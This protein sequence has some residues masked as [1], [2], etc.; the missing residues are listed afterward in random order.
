[1]QEG[2]YFHFLSDKSSSIYFQQVSFRIKGTLQLDLFK[3]SME[4]LFKRYDILRTIFTHEK[5]DLPL[6]VVLK[7]QPIDFYFE[8]ISE[9]PT[10]EQ[11]EEFIRKHKETEKE[12]PFDLTRDILMRT[13]LIQINESQYE[14]TWSFPHILMDGWCAHLLLSEL[15]EIYRAYVEDREFHLPPFRQYGE[16][17]KWLKTKSINKTKIYWEKYLSGYSG[18]IHIP[19]RKEYDGEMDDTRIDRVELELDTEKNAALNEIAGKNQVTLNSLIQAVWGILLSKFNNTQDMVFGTVVYG[20]PSEIK[21]VET[22]VGLFINTIPLRVKY[23]DDTPF[24][25]LIKTVQDDVV[26]SETHHYYSLAEIQANSSLKQ[27][28]LDHL[29]VSEDN[30]MTEDH[31]M[32]IKIGSNEESIQLSHFTVFNRGNYPINIIVVPR[33]QASGLKIIWEFNWDFYDKQEIQRVAA[34]FEL[35]LKQIILNPRIEISNIGIISDPEKNQLLY[36]FNDTREEGV[37]HKNETIHHLFEKQVEKTPDYIIIDYPLNTCDSAERCI[38]GRGI[39]TY[40]DLNEKSNQLARTLKGKG[41]KPGDIMGIMIPSS[42][43]MALGLLGI[44]K[45]GGAYL[46]I[47]PNYPA[48]RVN[49]ILKDSDIG[50]VLASGGEDEIQKKI[51]NAG[52]V[53]VLD[54]RNHE[55]VSYPGDGLNLQEGNRSSSL[56]YV[57]Y[58]SGT[59]GW[60]KGVPIDHKNVTNVL[61]HRKQ[62]FNLN[63][64]VTML[65]LLSYSFDGF[66]LS[67]FAPVVSGAQVILLTEEDRKDIARIKEAIVKHRITHFMAV[68]L[69]YQAIIEGFTPRE[70][71]SLEVVHIGADK[72]IPDILNITREN[73][74]HIEIS[75]EYGVTETTIIST[76]HRHQQKDKQ[77]HIG[78]P[79]WNTKIYIQDKRQRL[80]PLGVPGEICIGGAGIARGYLNNPELSKEKFIENPYIPGEKIYKSGDLGKHQPGGKIEFLGRIDNQVKI[81]GLRIEL[82]EIETQLLK[83]KEIKEAV[84]VDRKD[85]QGNIFLCAYVVLNGNIS[86]EIS[87]LRSLL[88]GKLPDYM[89]PAYFVQLDKIPLTDNNKVDRKALPDPGIKTVD[90]YIAPRNEIEEKLVEIWSDVLQIEK[91]A[92]GIDSNFFE[93]GGH[94]LKATILAGKIHKE[95]QVNIEIKNL[96]KLTSIRE[97]SGFI[98]ESKKVEYTSIEPVEKREYYGVSPAQKRLYLAQQTT[99]HAIGY[100]ITGFFKIHGQPDKD[101]LEY[102]FKQLE[103]RH[104]SLRTSFHLIEGMIIQKIHEENE[105]DFHIQYQESI[106][107]HKEEKPGPDLPQMIKNF[108]RPFDLS[109]LPLWRV[110]LIKCAE[111]EYIFMVDMH[112]IISDGWSIS[113]LIKEIMVSYDGKECQLAPLYI[114]YKEFSHWQ[115]HRL[116]CQDIKPQEEFWL[117]QFKGEEPILNLPTDYS[118][119]LQRSFEGKSLHFAIDKEKTRQLRQ[120]V[121]RTN[122]RLYMMLLAMFNIF[123]AKICSQEDVVLGIAVSGRNHVDLENTFG[124]FVNILPFRTEPAGEKSFTRYLEEV[125]E[126]TLKVYENQDY[127]YEDLVEK[128]VKTRDTSRNPLFDVMFELQD[129]HLQKFELTGLNLVPHEYEEEVSQ[130]DMFLLGEESEDNLFFNLTFSPVLFKKSTAERLANYF[131]KILS[132]ILA[133]PGKR[134]ADIDIITDE[135]KQ[136][137]LRE[138]NDTAAAYPHEKTFNQL[139]EE[140]VRCTPGHIALVHNETRITYN[141]LNIKANQLARVLRTKGVT[142]DTTV[143][144]M[145]DHSMEMI[146]GLIGILKA[147]ASFVPIDPAYP[148]ERVKV[149]L[150]DC[151][152]KILL[153][154]TNIFKHFSFTHLQSY[155]LTRGEF[156]ITEPRPPIKDLDSIQ[157]PDRSMVDYEKYARSI[158]EAMVKHSISLQA[159]RGC[160]YNCAYCC[161][162][163]PRTFVTRSA[164][165]IFKEV[166][167]YYDMGFRRFAFYDDIFNLDVENSRRFFRMISQNKMNVHLFFPTGFR[168]DILTKE[169]ID[170]VVEAGAVNIALSLETASP[171]MQKLIRKNLQIERFRENV[172]YLC[173]K[174]P[175]VILELQLM[176]GFPTETEE[177]AMMNL[178]FIKS[179]KWIHFPYLHILKIH[180][181]TDMEKIALE[182]GITRKAIERS[183]TLAYH[184]LPE[185]LPFDKNF[186]LEVQTEFLN[187]YFLR[188]ERLLHVLPYQ[189]KVLTKDEILQKY[190]SYLPVKINSIEALLQFVDITEQE[191]KVKD[192]LDEDFMSVPHLNEK[193][194]AYFHSPH[195]ETTRDALRILLLDLT[196][197]FSSDSEMLFDIL[198]P[199]LGLMYLMTHLNRHLGSTV[200]GKIAKSRVDF[201]SFPELKGLVE[202]FKPD[203][204]GLRSMTFYKELFHQTAALLRQWCPDIPIIA[205]GPYATSEYKTVLMDANIELVVLGEGE[206]TF[207]ELVEKI[208]GNGKKMPGEEALAAING[209]VYLH[210]KAGAVTH[211][212]REIIMLDA[213]PGVNQPGENPGYIVHPKNLAYIIFTSGSTGTPKGVMI[214]QQ[215]LNN[216]SHWHNKVYAVT[217]ADNATKYAGFGFDAS[218]WEIFPYLIAGAALH[219]IDDEIK[220]EM[221]RLNNYF[222]RHGISIGFLPTQIC[223]QFMRLE[224]RSLRILLTGGDKLR[225]YTPGN[226]QLV[227]NYGPSENTVVATNFPVDKLSANIPIG[228]PIYNSVIYILDKKLHLAP[229]GIAGEL[230]IGGDS[231]SRGYLNDIELT[232][233]KF[234]VNLF[235]EPGSPGHPNQRL[236]RTGDLARWLESGDIEFL[237]RIDRQVKIRGF[238]I[239][240]EEIERHLLNMEQIKETV[241]IAKETGTQ[242]SGPIQEI[243]K[244]LCAYLVSNEKVETPEIKNFL[245][246]RLPDYMIPAYFIFLPQI[247]LTPNGKIDHHALPDPKMESEENYIAPRNEIETELIEIW[248]D[249]LEIGNNLIG[250]NSNFFELGGNSINAV[251]MVS[252]INKTVGCELMVSDLFRCANVEELAK[253]LGDKNLND[254]LIKEVEEAEQRFK[255]IFGVPG[256][257]L[258]CCVGPVHYRVLFVDDTLADDYETILRFTRA[259]L[260]P[261]LNP[262]Y[263]RP[264]SQEPARE[265]KEIHLDNAEFTALLQLKTGDTR[266]LFETISAATS[267]ATSGFNRVIANGQSIKEYNVS[268]VQQNHFSLAERYGKALIPFD[269]YLDIHLFEDVFLKVIEDQGLLRSVLVEKEGELLWQELNPPT[270]IS[271]PYIDLSPYDPEVKEKLIIELV[272]QETFKNYNVEGSLLYRVILVR[273]DLRHHLLFM[274]LDHSIFDRI[275][276]E[277]IRSNIL[278]YYL[279]KEQNQPINRE[280]I[281]PYSQYVEHITRG[282]K[283]L[284]ETQL[285]RQYDLEDYCYYKRKC[286]AI[287][288][289]KKVGK[290]KLFI[291]DIQLTQPMDEESVW[292]LAY[293]VFNLVLK[294]Y[295]GLAKIPL[296][297]VSYGRHYQEKN[298]FDTV[299]E[300]LDLIPILADVDERNSQAALADANRK[301]EDT[302]LY[303]I[304]FL[305]LM[306]NK[307]LR[308]KW[309]KAVNLMAPETNPDDLLVI[310]NFEGK[311]PDDETEQF[312][313][314]GLSEALVPKICSLF[315]DCA[316]T[317][318]FLKFIITTPFEKDIEDLKKIFAEESKKF[319]KN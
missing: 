319:I 126:Y 186:T 31:V 163:W 316:Y 39:I 7:E 297:L 80:Q 20:R 123:L 83:V 61:L 129:L 255:E 48:E 136:Q 157:I 56:A 179:M 12:R 118:R 115:N 125:K 85:K 292:D 225:S 107:D 100:N 3:K 29:L 79:I 45:A 128:V 89:I 291:H 243:E 148:G 24:N 106:N 15:F 151:G 318:N 75:H 284:T 234:I 55:A 259:H 206:K 137:I 301:V 30:P 204:I 122:V 286:E 54:I 4:E 228:K 171:R 51:S 182:N 141:Q 112:H 36:E 44:L 242:R 307:K 176:H 308:N 67:F 42:L 236:F 271:I 52:K 280:S 223:E 146:I 251:R 158:A 193:L 224:N 290:F 194:S 164:E 154:K 178:D 121:A 78:H 302:S 120:L 47:D 265:E 296:K 138:F 306:L 226:Y 198:E 21:D 293:V 208:I 68:A 170:M 285:I 93:L 63:P 153:S 53:E 274:P 144:I 315:C 62:Q 98:N 46:P 87:T 264:I 105:T 104:E 189:M 64:G 283:N 97:L 314:A 71:A 273:K 185:T 219:V 217:A 247:P 266:T 113:I 57:I 252:T 192:F 168:G 235:E 133:S 295:F 41:L 88:S 49:Y 298:Y 95:F 254:R 60:P 6:Q 169:Y 240:K 218:I 161:R 239:E 73:Y 205:G 310:F 216:L 245:A 37:L 246:K 248:K 90:E 202:E 156:H 207:L 231:L 268:P 172:K 253:F 10:A 257:F 230:C 175:Q 131:K 32:N 201:D 8:D 145:V 124:M 184:E 312:F 96:F 294:R 142:A 258:T 210:K 303:N 35:I 173:E 117:A 199:P 140:Q 159:T 84:V 70:T 227:N 311:I 59:T 183:R 147:G 110:G 152:A 276:V 304:N 72:I 238:R 27:N 300:F 190:D 270:R 174:Y 40:K 188:K 250:I 150:D 9:M 279:T 262:H 237:G 111:K 127:P 272:N 17:I 313:Q 94:S 5:K 162:I 134:I 229:V 34:V 33:G 38:K 69:L 277:I 26:G 191:L 166:K 275:S 241:V 309:E 114:Q 13:S 196:Q 232:R 101:K 212:S 16:Y 256:E 222:E 22:I 66:V 86:M 299:G 132:T 278:S 181:N 180:A 81:R 220:L 77:I 282:P 149:M 50:L 249:V 281:S 209:I 102:I 43:E 58:T 187:D 18:V 19:G 195:Q 233:R 28:P 203:L 260:A 211:F 116:K 197:F 103:K 130:F 92:I 119:P 244:Y 215:S 139:F 214:E 109:R 65:Q 167:V 91:K 221:N 14:F 160:P 99:P 108:V 155:P 305:A 135:E 2:M 76:V 143:G 261:G 263:I 213:E 82:G 74:P 317:E 269:R 289:S 23:D 287:V 25:R 1:M 165:N 267:K 11:K 200:K 177:E 288:S